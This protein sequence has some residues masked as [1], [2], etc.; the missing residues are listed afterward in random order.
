[1]KK[2]SIHRV[3][4][5]SILGLALF[6]SQASASTES[7]ELI[8][9]GLLGAGVG[10]IS[11]SVS[12]GKAGKG[13]LIGAG[14]QILGNL[15]AGLLGNSNSYPQT[16]YIQPTPSYSTYSSYQSQP[17]PQ[18]VYQ[19]APPTR[20][21]YTIYRTEPRYFEQPVYTS[22]QSVPVYYAPSS[23]SYSKRILRQG[24]LGAGVGAISAET[25]GG[26]AGTGAL[27][28]AG[29]NVL[30]DALVELLTSY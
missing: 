8:R 14:T 5:S 17:Q 15:L 18:I 7:V 29:S 19:P 1:M 12:G 23:D 28:G 27:V 2:T 20:Q 26:K 11:S 21:T 25:A 22:R 16:T 6:S 10:A 24:L 13:A 4:L 9:Q 30:G 3:I